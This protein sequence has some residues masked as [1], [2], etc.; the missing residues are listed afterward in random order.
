MNM[1]KFSVILWSVLLVF[2]FSACGGEEE[3]EPAPEETELS[4]IGD[5]EAEI[6]FYE[7]T[8]VYR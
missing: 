3:K 8:S 2:A 6:F 1:K 4:Y 5:T 7:I